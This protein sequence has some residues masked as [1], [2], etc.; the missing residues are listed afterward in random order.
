MARNLSLALLGLASPAILVGLLAGGPGVFSTA[1]AVLVTA[2]PVALIALGSSPR[3]GG[4]LRTRLG[5][6]LLALFVLLAASLSAILG[7]AG[8]GTRLAGL[9][10]GAVVLVVGVIL[11][12]FVLVAAAHAVE[13]GGPR[14]APEG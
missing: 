7:L 14:A 11:A 8:T 1:L 3:P 5:L 10:A 13:P 2:F 4:R 6:A 9:P 12:P